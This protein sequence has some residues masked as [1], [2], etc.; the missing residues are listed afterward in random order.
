MDESLFFDSSSN[1]HFDSFSDAYMSN[2]IENEKNNNG[3][4]NFL[5]NKKTKHEN[6]EGALTFQDTKENIKSKHF[7]NI[8]ICNVITDLTLE[9]NTKEMII[10]TDS[11]Y[12]EED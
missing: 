8:K 1:G 5:L 4:L 6:I 7:S 12:T 2:N 11:I 3:S 9:K 10:Q